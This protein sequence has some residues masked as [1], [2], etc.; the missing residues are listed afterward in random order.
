MLDKPIKE[1]KRSQEFSNEQIA[2]GIFSDNPFVNN[3][4]NKDFFSSYNFL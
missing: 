4:E 2:N 1:T 3:L